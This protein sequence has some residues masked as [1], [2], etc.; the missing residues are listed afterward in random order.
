MP[1]CACKKGE[2]TFKTNR[3]KNRMAR[4]KGFFMNFTP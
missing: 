4:R 3:A 1:V 2:K